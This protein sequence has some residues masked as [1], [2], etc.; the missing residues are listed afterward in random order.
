MTEVGFELLTSET[1]VVNSVAI[2][3]TGL[4]AQQQ[5]IEVAFVKTK[6]ENRISKTLK[7]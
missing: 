5:E 7:S 1:V 6:P 3:Y 2:H 4:S